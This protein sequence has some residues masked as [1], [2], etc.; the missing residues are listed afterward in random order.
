MSSANLCKSI[1][2]FIYCWI[3][4]APISILMWICYL[5]IKLLMGKTESKDKEPKMTVQIT[6]CESGT[7][8]DEL[9]FIHGYPDDGSMWD[10]QVLALKKDYRCIVVTLPFFGKEEC[11]DSWGCSFP[12]IIKQLSEVIEKHS[13]DKKV[14]LVIHDWGSAYGFFLQKERP[15]LVSRIASLDIGGESDKTFDSLL[16]ALS[17]QL[18]FVLLYVIG[19]PIGT[20]ILRL[21]NLFLPVSMFGP[22][23]H[24]E[25][26]EITLQMYYPYWWLLVGKPQYFDGLKEKLHVLDGDKCPVYFA[27]GKRKGCR[28]HSD[29]WIQDLNKSEGCRAEEFDCGHWLMVEKPD[30][31]NRSLQKWLDDTN[32]KQ[33]K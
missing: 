32:K 28:F 12:E 4:F 18:F 14:S 9:L 33:S 22:L 11:P 23:S 24:K 10:K 8:K 16:F 31:L 29:K 26:S 3:I 1:Q 30:Q 21:W 2:L 7:P 17:Y 6:E 19:D 15:D 25:V 27:Y 13:K 5:P 20:F